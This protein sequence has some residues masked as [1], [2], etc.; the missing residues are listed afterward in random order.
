MDLARANARLKRL[1]DLPAAVY[2]SPSD[3]ALAYLRA[4]CEMFGFH[5]A[6]LRGDENVVYDPEGIFQAPAPRLQARSL[7]GHGQVVFAG[8]QLS[9][10]DSEILD[11]MVRDLSRELLRQT[12]LTRLSFEAQHDHLTGLPNRLHFMGLFETAL[13]RAHR[14]SEMLA[15]L[16][17]DL[18]RFKQ[19]N[20]TLGHAMGDRLL[21]QIGSRLKSL[22]P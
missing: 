19:V 20:D 4:G 21:Q 6:A 3:L 13:K 16:F 7:N 12:T 9:A 15:L 10:E 11:L 17:I 22:L 1:H 5:A 18:D 8:P 14:R 2:Q